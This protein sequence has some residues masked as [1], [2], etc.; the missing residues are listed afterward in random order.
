MNVSGDFV[1]HLLTEAFRISNL[2]RNEIRLKA[3]R[4]NS[5]FVKAHWILEPKFKL[6]GYNE[7]TSLQ[8]VAFRWP[9]VK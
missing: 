2:F 4:F 3:R 8:S 5:I 6:E 7:S 9:L 1:I